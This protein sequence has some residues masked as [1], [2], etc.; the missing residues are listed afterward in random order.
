MM[1]EAHIREGIRL[2]REREDRHKYWMLTDC[3]L[4]GE[5]EFEK[6]CQTFDT[7][8]RDAELPTL[9]DILFLLQVPSD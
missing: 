8:A 4:S 7:C 3:F 2:I 5:Y 6:I 9:E 1:R